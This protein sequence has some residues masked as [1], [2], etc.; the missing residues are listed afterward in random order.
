MCTSLRASYILLKFPCSQEDLLQADAG[1]E[2]SSNVF[3]ASFKSS[4]LFGAECSYWSHK[5][6]P[7]TSVS[8]TI[9]CRGVPRTVIGSGSSSRPCGCPSIS[10]LR[11][12]LVMFPGCLVATNEHIP[13]ER[14]RA[15]MQRLH[16]WSQS[17]HGQSKSQT[18]PRF[19]LHT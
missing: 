18:A 17:Q 6:I 16:S 7:F 8:S 19:V 4:L 13:P 10:S 9:S 14:K 5:L 12:E 15:Q 11:T 3:L 1:L 2:C